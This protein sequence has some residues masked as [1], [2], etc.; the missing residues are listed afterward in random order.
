MTNQEQKQEFNE[1]L[2]TAIELGYVYHEKQVLTPR[3][4]RLEY[5]LT[6]VEKSNKAINEYNEKKRDKTQANVNEPEHYGLHEKDENTE[7]INQNINRQKAREYFF[8]AVG[9]YNPR[10]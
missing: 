4:R 9:P 7:E 3:Q 8:P 2:D 10:H 5:L 1:N 6:L